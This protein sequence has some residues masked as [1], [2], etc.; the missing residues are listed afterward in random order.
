M[1]I[2][3]NPD[4]V[5]GSVNGRV[6]SNVPISVVGGASN[7]DSDEEKGGGEAEEESEDF[8]EWI[9]TNSDDVYDDG[10]D[11][12]GY[13]SDE[14]D[15][16]VGG[17]DDVDDVAGDGGN[18]ANDVNDSDFIELHDAGSAERVSEAAQDHASTLDA[19]WM[20]RFNELED[21]KVS[22]G[23]LPIE[24]SCVPAHTVLSPDTKW[25][26]QSPTKRWTTWRVGQNTAQGP[27]SWENA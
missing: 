21:F 22:A 16:V 15:D 8:D 3:K 6:S 7:L 9:E 5:N 12:T 4:A 14:S 1:P 17:G 2:S 27:Q 18:D 11:E 25:A 23:C 20:E 13:S 19:R 26:L 24:T 10:S